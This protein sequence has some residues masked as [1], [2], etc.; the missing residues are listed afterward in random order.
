MVTW[1][2]KRRAGWVVSKPT[3]RCLTYTSE[4]TNRTLAAEKSGNWFRRVGEAAEQ[5]IMRWFV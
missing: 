5:C 2:G 1:E 4:I 3:Y